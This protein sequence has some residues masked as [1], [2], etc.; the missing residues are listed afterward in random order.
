MF[1]TSLRYMAAATVIVLTALT[2]PVVEG[3]AADLFTPVDEQPPPDP[4]AAIT[5]RSR[6]V[7]IDLGQLDRVQAAVAE[8]AGQ[9]RRT[10]DTSPRTDKQRTAPTPGM[11]LTL[12]LFDDTVVTG[13]VEYTEATFSGGYAVAGRLVEEPLGTLTLVVNGET[14]AGTVRLLGETYRIRSVGAGQATI[15]EVEEPPF[16]C[17]VEEPHSETDHQH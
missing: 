13:I 1:V 7:A 4:L 5:L 2:A 16:T 6:V 3:Q 14:V 10:R 12:N 11:T 8:P 17:G 9:I 15:R